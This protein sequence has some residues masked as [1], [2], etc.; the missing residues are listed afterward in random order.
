M[1]YIPDPTT[2]VVREE[3]WNS[4]DEYG[5]ASAVVDWVGYLTEDCWYPIEDLAHNAVLAYCVD[6]FKCDI[7]NSGLY[8]FISNSKWGSF[9]VSHV[10]YGLVTIGALKTYELVGDVDDILNQNPDDLNLYLA[11]TEG[12]SEKTKKSITKISAEIDKAITTDGVS[13]LNREFISSF[14]NLSILDNARFDKEWARYKKLD[15]IR[16]QRKDKIINAVKEQ[17]TPVEK[18]LIEWCKK[19]KIPYSGPFASN[20]GLPLFLLGR[21]CYKVKKEGGKYCVL[22]NGVNKG[23]LGTV[24]ELG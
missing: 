18:K 15:V 16:K 20:N 13:G 9:Y 5:R 10:R 8:Q 19:K 22:W 6:L 11:G 4:E 21:D 17:F 1:S 2:V 23:V 12:V 14:K 3:T 7:N 24:E